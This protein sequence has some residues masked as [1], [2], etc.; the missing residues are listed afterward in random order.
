LKTITTVA[1]KDELELAINNKAATILCTV[2]IAEKVNRSYKMKT[3]SKFVLS[4]LAAS[5]VGIPF[6]SGLSAASA[7]TIAGLSG[8]ELAAVM[9]IV[10]LG[11]SLVEQIINKYDK[12]AVSTDLP[13]GKVKVKLE[14][15]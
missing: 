11:F 3:V 1:T 4:V 5:I 9:A 6:T 15:K 2:D 12:V 7:F 13:N 8:L 10:Y 14:R